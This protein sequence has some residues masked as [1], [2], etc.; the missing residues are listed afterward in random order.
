M[1]ASV[2]G[3]EEEFFNTRQYESASFIAKDNLHEFCV[4][5]A[6]HDFLGF[7]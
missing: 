7:G 4:H 6:T 2:K 3:L 1:Y 5:Q